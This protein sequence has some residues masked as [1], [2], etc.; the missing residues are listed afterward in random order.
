MA[1]IIELE[2]KGR[3]YTIEYNRLSLLALA[4]HKVDENDAIT[5]M[6]NMLHYGLLKHHKDNIPS[7]DELLDLLACIDDLE[8]FMKELGEC[9]AETAQAL[10]E[11]S[12]QPKNAV[13]RVK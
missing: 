12:N 8:G 5:S 13:W 10:K 3:T 7:D 9:V 1:R 4:Q 6:V 2:F 11:N